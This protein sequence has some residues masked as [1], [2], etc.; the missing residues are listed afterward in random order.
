MEYDTL[1]NKRQKNV[2]EQTYLR[3][4]SIKNTAVSFLAGKIPA[5]IKKMLSQKGFNSNNCALVSLSAYPE[6]CAHTFSGIIVTLSH[7]FIEFEVELNHNETEVAFVE[8]WMDIT[9]QTEISDHK[10]GIGKTF[11]ALAI[12]VLNEVATIG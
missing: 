3:K 1:K 9:S 6:C 7:Q 11:G 2:Q 5:G 4:H 10:R 12:E 8:K